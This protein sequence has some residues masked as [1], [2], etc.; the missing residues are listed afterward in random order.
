MCCHVQVFGGMYRFQE[1]AVKILRPDDAKAELTIMRKLKDC[2][3]CL[4]A[5]SAA[6]SQ[7]LQILRLPSAAEILAADSRGSAMH[8]MPYNTL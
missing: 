7:P 3:F 8:A 6:V 1:V 2:Q 5:I 4:P